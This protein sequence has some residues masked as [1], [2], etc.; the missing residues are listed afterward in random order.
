MHR[1]APV[2]GGWDL[3]AEGVIFL[4]QSPAPI[5]ILTAADTDIQTLAASVNKLPSGFPAIRVANLLQ[6]QQH[7]SIDSYAETVLSRAKIIVLRLLGGRSYWPYGLEVVKETIKQTDASLFILPGD[8]RPDPYAIADSTVPIDQVN[9][10]WRYWIEGGS[11]NIT[12]SLL[13]ISDTC[14]RTTYSPSPPQPIPRIG[15]YDWQKIQEENAFESQFFH[16]IEQNNP[17]VLILFYRAHYFSGNTLAIDS[18]CFSLM[19]QN[20]TP[21]PLFV[22]SLRDEEVQNTLLEKYQFYQDQKVN[23]ILNTT[24]FSLTKLDENV[25]KKD[26]VTFWQAFDA[27]VLQLIFSGG[28]EIQWKQSTLGLSPRDVAMNIALPEVD[29]RIIT[30]AVSF[31]SVKQWNEQLETDV[32]VYEPRQDRIDWVAEFAANYLQ[33]S[34]T[35]NSEKKNCDYFS[36]LS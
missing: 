36:Q 10:L 33:L 5:I 35:P 21:I 19:K 9:Q 11:H 22:S 25:E 8:D 23:L 1:I 7:L 3:S 24:S 28:T 26:T 31:K 32:V 6:L 20:I 29:G 17:V 15:Q 16:E 4:E 18:L 30:R 2:P 12:N 14:L 34:Q 13:F 27:T